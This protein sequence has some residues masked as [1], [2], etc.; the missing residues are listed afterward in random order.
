MKPSDKSAR[1]LEGVGLSPLVTKYA[2]NTQ[3]DLDACIEALRAVHQVFGNLLHE[4]YIAK[5]LDKLPEHIKA[6]LR[7]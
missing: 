7:E 4:S 3:A 6:R 1:A 2:R 5:A